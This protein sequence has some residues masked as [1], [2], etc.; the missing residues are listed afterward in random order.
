MAE[1]KSN[2]PS[3]L[4]AKSIA[5]NTSPSGVIDNIKSKASGIAS[6]IIKDIKDSLSV[7]SYSVAEIGRPFKFDSIVD[8]NERTYKYLSTRMGI[9]DLYPCNYGQAYT[10]NEKAKKS[11]FKYAV[12]YEKAMSRYQKMCSTYLGMSNP[13]SGLRIFLTEDSMVADGITTSY[14]DNFFQTMA[15]K[16]SNSAQMFTDLARSVNA[17]Q[18]NKAVDNIIGGID[19]NAISNAASENLSALGLNTNPDTVTG[20]VDSLKE[21]AAIVLKGNK[22]SLPKIWNDSDYKPVFQVSTKLFSPY[23]SPK[24]IQEFIVKPLT[25]ILLLGIPQSEDMIS[26]GRPFPL[27]IRSWG[28]ALLSLGGLTSVM[29]QRG[30]QDSAYNIYKQCRIINV[31]M[32]FTSLVSGAAAYATDNPT[33]PVPEYESTAYNEISQVITLNSKSQKIDG[34]LLPTLMPT[35]GQIIRSMQA[36]RFEDINTY[37]GP[38]NGTRSTTMIGGGG[39]SESS[40]GGGILGAASSI[41]SG[42][43]GAFS[44]A[45]NQA[46]SSASTQ[47]SFGSFVN[48]ALS[49]ASKTSSVISSVASSAT[50]VTNTSYALLNAVSGGTFS[51]TPFAKSIRDVDRTINGAAKTVNGTINSVNRLNNAVTNA[52]NTFNNFINTPSGANNVGKK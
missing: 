44:S 18:Y 4:N 32:E 17:G 36:V 21:G 48:S 19:S 11:L 24:A 30:G 23:G 37:Y 43:I 46:A 7:A 40:K 35:L 22:L 6:N 47:G 26:Y 28:N 13:P 2:D 8:P 25:L 49:F 10:F 31:N 39:G 51:N 41:L 16:M 50:Q 42:G 14:K 52:A 38:T 15:N 27:T 29:L 3:P 5:N 45:Y 1:S 20:I 9:L 34:S 12:G 33:L